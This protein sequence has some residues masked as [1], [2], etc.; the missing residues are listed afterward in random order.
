M[1]QEQNTQLKKDILFA[2]QAAAEEVE[3]YRLKLSLIGQALQDIGRA[4]QEHPEHVTRLPDPNSLYDYTEGIKTLR[5]GEKV[6]KMCE[7]LRFSEQKA[8]VAEA[9]TAVFKLSAFHD[10][11]A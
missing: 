9:R 8:K 4:L 10:S 1:T 3:A 7:D 6:I 5:D 2:A 11:A